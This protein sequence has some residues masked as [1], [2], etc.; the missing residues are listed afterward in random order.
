MAITPPDKIPTWATNE[1][2]NSDPGAAKQAAGWSTNEAPSSGHINWLL[3]GMGGFIEL[4]ANTLKPQMAFWNTDFTANSP[5]GS[6]TTYHITYLDTFQK[7]YAVTLQSGAA[8][9]YEST[10]GVTWG[11]A[12]TL[13]ASGASGISQWAED[14]TNLYVAVDDTVYS[15]TGAVASLSSDSTFADITAVVG[16]TWD[17]TNGV[18]IGAGAGPSFDR[19]ETKNGAGS[20]TVRTTV[21]TS[22]VV[23]LATNSSGKSVCTTDA[24]EVFYTVNPEGGTWSTST[25]PS[26]LGGIIWSPSVGVFVAT[27]SAHSMY[28]SD[29]GASFTDSGFD[30]YQIIE[31]GEFLY[32]IGDKTTQDG[33]MRAYKQFQPSNAAVNHFDFATVGFRDYNNESDNA[34]SS[35]YSANTFQGGQGRMVWL[36]DT[37]E[38]LA[39]SRFGASS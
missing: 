31:N 35:F 25:P 5:F 10:D 15:S 34:A 33:E 9:A 27:N 28:F 39:V 24:S 7:W 20:W 2:N 8:K 14:G 11:S 32:A 21:A 16:L 1:T 18:L 22:T 37:G 38:K 36:W 4:F 23:S 12:K 26:I 3:N 19:I 6:I 17:E 13:K 29:T 30:A